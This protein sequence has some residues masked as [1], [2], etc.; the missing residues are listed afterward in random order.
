MFNQLRVFKG[1]V[2]VYVSSCLR[3]FGLKAL[4]GFEVF[5]LKGCDSG[6]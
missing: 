1:I 5:V 3:L 6:F 4:R 2:E